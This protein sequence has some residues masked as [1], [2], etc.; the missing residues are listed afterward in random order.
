[1]SYPTYVFNGNVSSQ[2]GFYVT[3]TAGT[4]AVIQAD[5]NKNVDISAGT[6]AAGTINFFRDSIKTGP[7]NA[8]G[9]IRLDNSAASSTQ[10]ASLTFAG[11]S[12]TT[13]GTI[14]SAN[15]LN[16]FLGGP[17]NS[18]FIYG[19]TASYT[20]V[21]NFTSPG[22]LTT[23]NGGN[24]G[25][26]YISICHGHDT[27]PGFITFHGSTLAKGDNT[28]RLSWI[29]SQDSG[30]LSISAKTITICPDYSA[31]VAT[32]SSTGL[33]MSTTTNINLSTTTGGQF[34]GINF[35]GNYG[36]NQTVYPA[37]G[38][39]IFFNQ[40]AKGLWIRDNK[41]DAAIATF[42]ST[43][44]TVSGSINIGGLPIT[45]SASD[46]TFGTGQVTLK[47]ITGNHLI[48]A[49]GSGTT[50]VTGNIGIGLTN[51]LYPI[52]VAPGFI[53]SGTSSLNNFSLYNSTTGTPNNS[54]SVTSVGIF[55]GSNLFCSALYYGSDQRIKTNIKS[56]DTS[57][58][59]VTLNAVQLRNFNYIDTIQYGTQT[60]LG[61]IAQEVKDT[62]P[63]AATILKQNRIP[64]IMKSSTNIQL[65]SD[66]T[67][68]VIS[69]VI[70]STSELTVGGNVEL[71]IED[72]SSALITCVVSFTESQ[73]VVPIWENFDETKKIY[74]YGALIDNF[75]G[76][77]E[78]QFISL[79]MGGVQELSK[80]NDALTA[81]VATLQTQVNTLMQ[82]MATLLEKN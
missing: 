33:T 49:S 47:T 4:N 15:I 48:L 76:V 63:N 69:V 29:S 75:G 78:T 41:T 8:N 60:E 40:Y 17:C 55:C 68:V 18:V 59:L 57:A 25:I 10:T 34:G 56:A 27:F 80:R 61:F 44:L 7:N 64:S 22:N 23:I 72:K 5:T 28:G 12:N 1:M 19:G 79:C 11:P 14:T 6:T 65:T 42:S 43:G 3:N 50:S 51:A 58:L 66:G 31:P 26:G 77:D 35:T 24:T 81:Q 53:N 62:Y 21:V 30:N 46:I 36:V 20:S 9:Y 2:Q 45:A 67:N 71:V 70:P 16:T 82:Q 54:T 13:Y 74:V 73:L 32:F 39:Y 52:H 37:E 38:Y